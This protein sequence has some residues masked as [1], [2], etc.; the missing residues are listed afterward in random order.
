MKL[1]KKMYNEAIDIVSE[2]ESRM[3][4]NIDINLEE[5]KEGMV[6]RDEL[7]E[8]LKEHISYLEYNLNQIDDIENFYDTIPKCS[9]EEII[10]IEEILY[11]L[12]QNLY[13]TF[14]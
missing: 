5:F 11:K 6:E 8:E 9:L 2:Y 7:C 3:S 13:Q 14:N 4:Q 1:T 10:K 12:K